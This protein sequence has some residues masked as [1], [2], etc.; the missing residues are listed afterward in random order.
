MSR[1]PSVVQQRIYAW[2]ID[3]LICVGLGGLF[4]V[5]GWLASTGYWL[6]RDG[7]FEA[8]SVGKRLM[9]LKV[10]GQR[11]AGSR[12]PFLNSFLRNVLWIVPVMNLLMGITG[13]HALFH[14]SAGRHWGDRLAD[15]RVVKA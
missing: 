7:L 5:L 3:A 8:Q 4:G 10:S 2:I 9:G 12:S 6:F 1:T 13:L 14:D 15:T 11:S